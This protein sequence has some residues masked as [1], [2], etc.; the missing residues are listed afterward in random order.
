MPEPLLLELEHKIKELVTEN[1]HAIPELCELLFPNVSGYSDVKLSL[2]CMMANPYDGERRERIHVLLHG[3]PGCGKTA[4]ME[5]LE[6]NWGALYLSMDPSSASL[7]GDGRKD[8]HGIKKLHQYDG[9]IVCIDDFELM[10]ELNTLRDVME[11]GKYT[12]TKG[13]THT[14]YAARCRIIAA[15]NDIAKVPAPVINRFDLIHKFDAPTIQQ[16]MAIL[17][18]MLGENPDEVNYQPMLQYYYSFVNAHDP[19]YTP[20]PEIREIFK[21][22]FEKYGRPIESGQEGKEGKEGRW[23][24]GVLRVAKAL[25][26]LG[27]TDIGPDQISQALEMKQQSDQIIKGVN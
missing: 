21:V 22:H 9:G 27:L 24:A 25:A 23:I 26:R 16:S 1:D 2:M 5:P 18:L 10:K 6:A 3:K 8:D 4:L 12:I 15:T 20:K 13:G 19:V 11:S 14:E 7:K 17:D